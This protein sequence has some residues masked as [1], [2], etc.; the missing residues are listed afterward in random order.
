MD[1]SNDEVIRFL[2]NK[3]N[4]AINCKYI[5][6]DN[7]VSKD[8]NQDFEYISFD[9]EKQEFYIS[10]LKSQ[11]SIFIY[12]YEIMFIDDKEK[13][14][15]TISDVYENIVYEGILKNL[16]HEQILT[17]LCQL[18]NLI[19]GSKNIEVLQEPLSEQSGSYPKY[20]Y[21]L[22]VSNPLYKTGVY[23]FENIE[24]EII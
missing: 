15:Y 11:T 10:F 17:M 24:I 2:I 18:I 19:Y 16:S 12:N 21:R 14:K 5:I 13:E 4:D 23:K 22:K 9:G 7:Y 6:D 1:F 3:L 20:N 8:C